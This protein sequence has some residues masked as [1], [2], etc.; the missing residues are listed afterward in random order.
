M[1]DC[2]IIAGHYVSTLLKKRRLHH[3]LWKIHLFK[4]S[5]APFGL[6][7]GEGL[8][9]NASIVRDIFKHDFLVKMTETSI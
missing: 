4:I 3:F 2:E 5:L 1:L 7:A 6:L 8:K 9:I